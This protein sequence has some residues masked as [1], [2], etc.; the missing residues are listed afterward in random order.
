MRRSLLFLFLITATL[1]STATPVVAEAETRDLRADVLGRWTVTIDFNGRTSHPTLIV[2]EAEDG[3]TGTWE[4]RRGAVPLLE[5]TYEE[6]T[7]A[8]RFERT[9]GEEAVTMRLYA[10]IEGDRFSG[11]LETGQGT[12]PLTGIRETP[13]D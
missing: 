7:L 10:D 13:G 3:L 1:T 5:V 9:F 12:V 6:G 11:E 8:A 4:G 2:E